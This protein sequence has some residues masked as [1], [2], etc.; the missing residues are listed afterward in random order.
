MAR[1]DP[2]AHLGRHREHPRKLIEEIVALGK[3]VVPRLLALVTD[4]SAWAPEGTPANLGALHALF[5]LRMIRD[6]DAVPALVDVFARAPVE[7]HVFRSTAWALPGLGPTVLE[8]LLS[9][10]TEGD[11]WVEATVALAECGVQDPR[12]VERIEAALHASPTAGADAATAYGDPA[13]VPALQR[14]FDVNLPTAPE[15]T[16]AELQVVA[17][18]LEAI[19]ELGEPDETRAR[20]L[21]MVFSRYKHAADGDAERLQRLSAAAALREN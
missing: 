21:Q 13:L 20:R 17:E 9:L 12:I 18:L 19:L 2:V 16:N 10:A 4:P 8:P 5:A 14:A 11:R 6:A 7:S 15:P 3:P 1:K